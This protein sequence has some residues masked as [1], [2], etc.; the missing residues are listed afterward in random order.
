M[1]RRD[2]ARR[3]DRYCRAGEPSEGGEAGLSRSAGPEPGDPFAVIASGV[4]ILL[5]TTLVML[6]QGDRFTREHV[7]P[8]LLCPVLYLL[9]FCGSRLR[10]GQS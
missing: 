2:H 1:S 6:S 5:P 7:I 4:V 9:W 8:L 10:G 3:E